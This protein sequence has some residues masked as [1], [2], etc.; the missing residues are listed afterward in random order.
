MTSGQMGLHGISLD[1]KRIHAEE[2]SYILSSDKNFI[3]FIFSFTG[4]SFRDKELHFCE[5]G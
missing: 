3:M 2:K 4:S 1:H 5:N